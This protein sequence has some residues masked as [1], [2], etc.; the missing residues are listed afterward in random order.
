MTM[1]STSHPP[2]LSTVAV[3]VLSVALFHLATGCSGGRQS[4]VVSPPSETA[5][6]PASPGEASPAEPVGLKE[7]DI[8]LVYPR[9][10]HATINAPASFLVGCVPPP[11]TSNKTLTVNGAPVR[12][13]SAGFYA[14][15]VKLAYG[16]NKFSLVLKGSRGSDASLSVTISR[17]KPPAMVAVTPLKILDSSLAPGQDLGLAAGDIVRL[18]FRGS[19]GGTARAQIGN[20]LIP[21]YATPK[22]SSINRGRHTAYGVTSQFNPHS[23]ADLYSGF[24]RVRNDDHFNNTQVKYTLTAGG[25]TVATT[26]SALLTV[27]EQP[28]VARTLHENTIVRVAPGAARLTPL[29]EGVR[30]LVDGFHGDV[31]RCQ[32]YQGKHVWIEKKEMEMDGDASEPPAA[33]VSTINLVPDPQTNGVKVVIPLNQR[34]P[35]QVEQQVAPNKLVLKVFGATADTDW[36]TSKQEGV[37]VL[38]TKND[39]VNFVTWK[40]PEDRLYQA[41]IDLK[42]Q[43]Q[44][45]YW[46]SY[47]GT[48]LVLHIKGAPKVVPGS[49]TLNGLTVCVDPGHGGKEPGSIGCNGMKESTLNLTIGKKV[50]DVL[51]SAGAQVIMTRESDSFVSLADRVL[52]AE[53]ANADLLISVHN[54]ALP[55]GRNPWENSGTSAYWYHIQSLA[56][57]RQLQSTVV[58]VTGLPNYGVHY[59]N[60]ALCRPTRMPAA[61][62]EIGF[63][64]HPEEYAQLLQ[65]AV[66][67]KVA[68]AVTQAVQKFL[69]QSIN[70]SVTVPKTQT[71]DEAGDQ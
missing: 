41:T 63:M 34:L 14:H 52:I 21:L 16:D 50:A 40:Q 64:I 26:G 45:G 12:V 49:G 59:Q 65:P 48:D 69:N 31:W 5:I 9:Q 13:S 1:P 61:L 39:V 47:E 70:Q 19:P 68:Q 6:A 8:L 22:K 62:V 15:V 51:R 46:V 3:T 57:A 33:L 24:Y 25:T 43:Q 27:V 17:Q 66:Q 35:Y 29:T 10:K 7:G 55:D 20:R 71:Q 60:L 28:F 32:L 58:G 37:P 67:D 42:Q 30:L 36:V 11:R 18:S 56:L 38:N 54:N 4:T 23:Q 53:N 44:W 2:A